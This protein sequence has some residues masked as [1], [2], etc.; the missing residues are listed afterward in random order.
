MH[1]DCSKYR[2]IKSDHIAWLCH[3]F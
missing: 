3:I 1:V 2:L